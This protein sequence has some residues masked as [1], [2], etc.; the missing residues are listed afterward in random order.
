MW[1]GLISVIVDLN[2]DCWYIQNLL[3][4]W[5]NNRIV[6]CI[7]EFDATIDPL[8]WVAFTTD[9]YRSIDA[10]AI[11]NLSSQEQ[12]QYNDIQHKELIARLSITPCHYAE[13]HFIYCFSECS[14]AEGYFADFRGPRAVTTIVSIGASSNILSIAFSYGYDECCCV[15]VKGDR[16]EKLCPQKTDTILKHN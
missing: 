7:I 14:Y 2:F 5:P 8:G 3:L 6:V 15:K 13:Y 1:A 12:A 11:T 9:I 10:C 16:K 4:F